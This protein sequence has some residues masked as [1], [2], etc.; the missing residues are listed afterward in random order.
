M[1]QNITYGSTTTTSAMDVCQ[2]REHSAWVIDGSDPLFPTHISDA[3]SD[4]EWLVRELNL[5]LK[6]NL[7]R[8]YAYIC[9][10]LFQG[11]ADIHKEYLKLPK[12]KTLCDLEMPSACIAVVRMRHDRLFYY[13]LGSC[14][15]VVTFHDGTARRIIDLRLQE[16]DARLLEIAQDLRQKER[17]PLFRARNFMDHLL[18][19]NRVRRNIEGGYFVL[20]EDQ[21][22]V[23]QG[24]IGSFPAQDVKS[25]TMICHGFSQYFNC[26]KV[27]R[28]LDQYLIEQRA[29]EF[30]EVYENLLAKKKAN[31][32]LARYMQEKLSGPSTIV[33]F[34][35][36]AMPK[37]AK[38]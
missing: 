15:L 30:V 20:G 22:A 26:A 14:E 18:V 25:I 6:S 2:V 23:K 21:E 5:Y 36:Q 24:F 28:N 16:L 1:F 4:G 33:S 37:L 10:I 38:R 17:M 35:V 27:V 31:H 12:A 19:E 29:P 8:P 9:D 13:V 32:E 34:D 7:L 3:P 11:L